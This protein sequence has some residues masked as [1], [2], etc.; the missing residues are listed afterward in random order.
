MAG[1]ITSIQ[2]YSCQLCDCFVHH[3]HWLRIGRYIYSYKH[4]Q[5]T[6]EIHINS[7]I[8]GGFDELTASSHASNCHGCC[9]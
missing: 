4:C 3:N 6:G 2:S 7:T 8:F 9:W 5:N 1:E